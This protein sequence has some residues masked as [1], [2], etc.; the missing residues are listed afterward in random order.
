MRP[1]RT[2]LTLV[3]LGLMTSVVRAEDAAAPA[4]PPAGPQ[5]AAPA[6]ASTPSLASATYA[7]PSTAWQLHGALGFGAADGKYGD[8][9]QKPLQ[10]DIGIAKRSASGKWLF[11]VNL[12][13]GSMDPAD[14]PN[15]APETADA[16]LAPDL[17]WARLETSFSVRRVFN[18]RATLPALPR[19]PHRDRAHP[20]AQRAVLGAAPAR[21]PRARRQPH[22][23]R[24]RHRLHAAA[25]LRGGARQDPLARRRRL[26]HLLQDRGVRHVP[27]RPAGR[28]LRLSSG[29]RAWA[30]TGG[31]SRRRRSIRRERRSW[32]TRPRASRC[33]CR[34]PTATATPGACRAAGAG[35]P[36]RCSRSTGA[37]RCSTSTCATRTSTR[38]ARAASGR[39]SRKASPTTTT[40]SRPT[41]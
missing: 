31:R 8:V 33:R 14:D 22:R 7:A 26:R 5:A 24:E 20:P 34:R 19:G 21:G 6:A 30:S 39:T 18:P 36:P 9:L 10:W 41:S 17:E 16:W 28:R 12:Q 23:A 1:S 37:R 27:A 40:S 11:G 13:F 35:R 3:V 25:G 2:A 32:S 29:A 4:V 38:S 15:I